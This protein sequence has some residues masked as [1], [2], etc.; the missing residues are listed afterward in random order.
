M[1]T[2]SSNDVAHERE[3]WSRAD[4]RKLRPRF[5]TSNGAPPR[6]RLR[7]PRLPEELAAQEALFPREAA[8]PFGFEEAALAADLYR[9]LGRPR[10]R[11]ISLVVAAC[12]LTHGAALW[13]LS[14]RDFRDVAN[15]ALFVPE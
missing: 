15:L 6:C 8:V 1:L 9:A 5:S 3:H 4:C 7:G 14:A 2:G 12:A 11:E 10:G 13:T